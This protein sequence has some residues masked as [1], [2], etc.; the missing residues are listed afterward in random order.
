MQNHYTKLLW[1]I[2][3][4]CGIYSRNFLQIFSLFLQDFVRG[5]GRPPVFVKKLTI[6]RL[7]PEKILNSS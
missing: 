4:F 6:F 1:E 3:Y 7:F 2:Q 5:N